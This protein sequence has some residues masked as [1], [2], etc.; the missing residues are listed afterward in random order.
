MLLIHVVLVL[1][2][3][4]CSSCFHS[5]VATILDLILRGKEHVLERENYILR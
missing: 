5:S 2:R 4:R 1:L 3:M